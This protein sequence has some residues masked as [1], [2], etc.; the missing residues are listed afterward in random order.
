[1]P[2]RTGVQY[3]GHAAAVTSLCFLP[4]APDRVASCDQQGTIHVWSMQSGRQVHLF[5]EPA[6]PRR[7]PGLAARDSRGV[8]VYDL[9]SDSDTDQQ[10]A[11]QEASLG[12]PSWD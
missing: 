9:D 6:S 7:A 1:M 10:Q 2:A 8:G 3:T 11:A 12:V 5:A 4:A